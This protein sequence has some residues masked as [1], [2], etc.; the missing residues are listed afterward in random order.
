MGEEGKEGRGGGTP[1]LEKP[2]VVPAMVFVLSSHPPS[3]HCYCCHDDVSVAT[4]PGVH[5]SRH[6]R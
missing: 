6:L 1:Q 3:S 5:H 2:V 4:T